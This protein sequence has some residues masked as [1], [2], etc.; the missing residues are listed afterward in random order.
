MQAKEIS[1]RLSSHAED[2][3]RHLLPAGKLKSNEW[4][5]GN[6]AGDSGDSM[7]VT[8]HG[9]KAGLWHDFATGEGGDL[10]DLWSAQRRIS[11]SDAFKEAK[12]WLGVSDPAFTPERASNFAKPANQVAAKAKLNDAVSSY[13][14]HERKL[15]VETLEVFR[16]CSEGEW[17]I[18]PYW[19]N[20]ELIQL[21]RLHLQRVDGKKN[22]R[23]ERN[24]EPS[25]FGWDTLPPNTREV[26]IT[27]GE[28]DAMTLYQYGFP[29]LSVPFGGGAGKKH[30]WLEHEY[31]RLQV[32]DRIYLCFDQDDVGRRAVND[33]LD[34]LG[35]H[36][37]MIVELPHKDANECLQKGVSKE[38]IQQC[39]RRSISC[40]PIELKSAAS[41]CQD[42]INEFDSTE[43]E[44]RGWGTPWSKMQGKLLF[45]PAELS[46]WTG[47]NGHGKSQVIGQVALAAMRQGARVCIASLELRPAKLLWRLTRQASA[48]ESPSPE[49]IKAIHEWYQDKLWIFDVVGTAKTKRLL[50]VFL[51]A[52]QRYGIDVFIIDSLMKCGI[53]EDDYNAQKLFVE[54]LC[55][56]K[57]QHNCHIHLIA[58]PRKSIDEF[59]APGKMD[60]KGSGA[61]TDLADSCFSVW[62][63]KTKEMKLQ[64][65]QYSSTN[66]DQSVVDKYDCLITCSK[67]RNGDW[68]SYITLWF[69]KSSYQFVSS[70]SAKPLRYV[71]F[72]RAT[73]GSNV[74]K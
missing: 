38:A 2:V 24:C 42:V 16:V 9:E 69:D 28:I 21:K 3:V 30:Q 46:V 74:T 59:K 20:D 65:A 33:L 54:E 62:R 32:F 26:T 7:T 35:R 25:L 40:D 44:V 58:H 41:F 19:R 50:D 1:K 67:Q 57:H 13:L 60:I 72:S 31:D 29:A 45:R 27:E 52:L 39:F 10:L 37:C 53:A 47:T 71:D 36:R 63:N 18:F 4:K 11:L 5:V 66:A 12:Q 61:I 23:V 68:E 43:R 22:I 15:T 64:K 48:M 6:T 17:I 51:Y 73:G 34:R 14:I 55:D 70:S 49:Y 8:L 56:F